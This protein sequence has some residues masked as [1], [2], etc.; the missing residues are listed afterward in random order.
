[1]ILKTTL[2]KRSFFID[3]KKVGEIPAIIF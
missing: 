1:L 2:N 3:A